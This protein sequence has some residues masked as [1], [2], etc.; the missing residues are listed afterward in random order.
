MRR[1][2][3]VRSR[4]A[5]TIGGLLATAE[6]RLAALDVE[7]PDA[8]ALWLLS[9]VL[10]R[11]DDPD[12]LEDESRTVV[13]ED[14]EARFWKLVDRRMTHEPYQYI[15][16]VADFRDELMAVEHGVFLP[17]LQSERLCD[18][19]ENWA[20]ERRTPSGGWRVADL[21]TGC[22]AIA[23]SLALGPLAPS[24]VLAV[25]VAPN[26]LALARR[27]AR[28][29]GVADRVSVVASDWLS[30]IRPAPVLDV[31]CA[32]P[33][34]LN[35][36]E[37][38]WLSEESL[39]WEPLETFFG[40]PSG[41]ALLER[42]VDQATARLRPGGLLACQLEDRQAGLLEEWLNGDPDHPLTVEWI[43]IDE[44]GE[45][46]AILAVRD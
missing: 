21:G 46:E 28:R 9:H 10:G 24:R 4:E 20:A 5:A 11:E 8:S 38:E 37:E 45:A 35:P 41:D 26:A 31:V 33:P 1:S 3:A 14:D 39:R 12:A 15:V 36:G 42:I 2:G 27:N 13:S 34:Y 44:D 23:V 7:F 6:K 40:E 29:H 43:L 22:G 18:E 16:G 17:R 19:V 30:A 32:V 25:D